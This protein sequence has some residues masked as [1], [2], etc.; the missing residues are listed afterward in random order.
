MDRALRALHELLWHEW[1]GASLEQQH[2][3][4]FLYLRDMGEEG[5]ATL[6][7]PSDVQTFRALAP[8]SASEEYLALFR[9]NLSILLALLRNQSGLHH[10][11][12]VPKE[13]EGRMKQ[14]L[15]IIREEYAQPALSLYG[16]GEKLGVSERHL[17]RLFKKCTGQSFR[18]YLREFRIDKAITLL[19]RSAHDMKS[20]AAMLGYGNPSYFS[21]DFRDRMGCTPVEFRAK[22]GTLRNGIPTGQPLPFAARF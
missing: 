20:I 6:A 8:D 3:D 9:S 4:L 5:A 1:A 22:V 10:R 13:N 7:E 2:A 11:G 15:Q 12:V 18:Q 14:V 17:G 16:L 19:S 21:R